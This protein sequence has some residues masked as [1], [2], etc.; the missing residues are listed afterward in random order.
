MFTLTWL[1]PASTCQT[2]V[3]FGRIKD[4][5]LLIIIEF[6]DKYHL[7]KSLTAT[8]FRMAPTICL[9]NILHGKR[10]FVKKLEI[11]SDL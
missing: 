11:I 9:K 10:L 3:N 5:S 8:S 1:L 2:A 4:G 6:V 7:I